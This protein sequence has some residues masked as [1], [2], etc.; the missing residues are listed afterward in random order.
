[1]NESNTRHYYHLKPQNA[2]SKKEGKPALLQTSEAY[3]LS[4]LPSTQPISRITES[5]RLNVPYKHFA[6]KFIY[7]KNGLQCCFKFNLVAFVDV[8]LLFITHSL[9]LSRCADFALYFTYMYS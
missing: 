5:K 2:K 3:Q 1:M 4:S 9:R 7:V 8:L 6:A